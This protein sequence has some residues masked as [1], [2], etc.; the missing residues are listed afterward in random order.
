MSDEQRPEVPDARDAPEAAD[1][2]D[3]PAAGAARRV[4]PGPRALR[5]L[6]PFE[7]AAFVV[8]AIA[9]LPDR[10]PIAMPLFAVASVSRWVRRR[11]WAEVLHAERWVCAV[12]TV[13]GLVALAGAL[14]LGTPVVE[15]LTGRGVEWSA[16]PIVRGNVVTGVMVAVIAAVIAAITEL[17]LRGWIVERVL[18]LSPGPAVLPVLIGALAEALI[19]PGGLAVRLGAAVFGVGLGAIYVAAGRD[20]MAPIYARAAF[21]L[22]AVV[23]EMLRLIG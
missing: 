13:A 4:A 20:V 10:I 17:A 5:S 11:T 8:L 23:L 19:A 3:A 12:S 21:A 14:A 18:E 22:G 7:I 6:V 2:R 1:L 16:A 9:P 15:A